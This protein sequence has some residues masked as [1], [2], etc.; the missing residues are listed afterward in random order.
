MKEVW[1]SFR[2]AFSMYS[3]FPA[4]QIK[5]TRRN[6]K[7]ILIFVPLVGAIIGFILKQWQVISPY[8]IDKDLLGAVICAMLPIFLSGG[9]FL[10]G[11]FRTVDALSSHQPREVKL[12]ILRIPTADTSQLL[13]V[14]AISS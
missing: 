11:F 9:A 12:E 1:A 13:S 3:I 7:Y 8:L 5:K 4:R 6:M 10:D 14:S 2:L